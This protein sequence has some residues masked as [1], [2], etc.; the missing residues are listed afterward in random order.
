MGYLERSISLY[1]HKTDVLIA[2]EGSVEI[3]PSASFI[4]CAPARF[5]WPQ[6]PQLLSNHLRLTWSKLCR[7]A[8][9]FNRFLLQAVFV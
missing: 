5:E 2:D 4:V 7:N 9:L 8:F 1:T 3:S 6:V